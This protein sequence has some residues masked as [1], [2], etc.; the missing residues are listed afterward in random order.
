M[1]EPIEIARLVEPSWCEARI[2]ELAFRATAGAYPAAYRDNDRAIIDDD[3]L[4]AW[5]FARVRPHL[6]GELAIDGERWELV[7]LN[8][9]F[10]AC[11]YRGGQAF[12]IHRDG[13]HVPS[14]NLRSYLTLQIYLDAD[15]ALAGGCTRFYRDASGAELVRAIAPRAGTAIVFD[16]REWHDGEPVTRG[17]KHILRTDVMYR[18]VGEIAADEPDVIGR[19]RGYV[20][21]VIACRDGSL[22]SAGRDGCI[23]RWSSRGATCTPLDRGSIL[24]LVE[25]RRGTLWSGTRSGCVLAGDREIARDLGAVLALACDEA[26]VVAATAHGM[27]TAFTSS[28]ER[29]WTSPAHAGWAWAVAPHSGGVAS[30]GDDGRIAHT[31]AH[32]KTRTLRELDAPCRT[33][34]A[35]TDGT[36]IAGDRHGCVQR[37]HAHDA[38]AHDARAHDGR[39]HD[40][41]ITS[42]CAVGDGFVSAGEDGRVRRWPGGAE[43]ARFTDHVTC[44]A[45]DGSGTLV[46]GGYDGA[47]RRLG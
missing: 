5:L 31:D 7:G 13:A 1:I 2:A 35:L 18:R 40:A 16:H 30:T 28:G 37:G 11:R 15:P 41:A 4:A 19:H 45:V 17:I 36:L 42:L 39:A 23:R 32:G 14:D 9:R 34:V 29:R 21:R 20:W 26:G 44:L 12:C 47:L 43:L 10:R 38:R 33:L 46:A 22:A 27:L 6:R 8:R 24:A 25:D 3:A